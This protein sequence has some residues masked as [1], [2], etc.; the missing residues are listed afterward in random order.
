MNLDEFIQEWNGKF[1]SEDGSLGNDP[2][3]AQCVCVCNEWCKELGI[4]PFPGNAA[5]FE[6]DS[7]PDCDWVDNT[8]TNAPP[9]GAIVV[10]RATPALPYG[11]VDIAQ[12]GATS[13]SF[14]GFDQN[15]PYGAACHSQHHDYGGVAGWLVPHVIEHAP[16]EQIHYGRFSGTVDVDVANVR[17]GYSVAEAVLYQV[18]KGEALGFDG[19]VH[20]GVGIPD[21]ITG[22]PDDRWFHI[23]SD[24]RE[25][26]IA[27]ALVNG[28][29]NF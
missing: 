4:E 9:E 28:N 24:S 19:Y 1:I 18:R 12:A 27:S 20:T 7:H 5:N 29:P 25:G 26:W 14:N 23:V 3:G 10:W 22:Q 15:W 8:P 13:Q 17:Q 16:A 2:Y 6:F 21:A 11:H